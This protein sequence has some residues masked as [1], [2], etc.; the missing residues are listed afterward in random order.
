[1]V[2]PKYAFVDFG[3]REITSLEIVFRRVKAFLCDFHR[4]QAWHRWT[5]KIENGFS[6][7]PIRPK[8]DYVALL[9]LQRTQ[10]AK[11]L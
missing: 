5:S 7:F 10:I 6:L 2:S 11:L 8:L 4:E 1:M 9:I 3:E